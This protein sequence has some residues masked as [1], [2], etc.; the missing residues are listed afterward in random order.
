MREIGVVE[1]IVGRAV[2]IAITQSHFDA[3]VSFAYNVGTGGRI[4]LNDLLEIFAELGST[5]V[6]PDYRPPREGDVRHSLA[7][8]DR[9][10][11]LLGYEI[12]VGLREGLERTWGH[13]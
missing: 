13:F 4:S 2:T 3:L 10:R 11:D 9:A 12:E 5:R 7:S 1:E 6:E 8:I